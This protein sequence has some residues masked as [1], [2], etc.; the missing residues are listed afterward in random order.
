MKTQTSLLSQPK[1]NYKKSETKSHSRPKAET[2]PDHLHPWHLEWTGRVKG[3]KDQ[4]SQRAQ[5]WGNSM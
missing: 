2:Q 5:S 1:E 3:T 4:S